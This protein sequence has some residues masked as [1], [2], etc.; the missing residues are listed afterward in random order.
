MRTLGVAGRTDVLVALGVASLLALAG[1]SGAADPVSARAP[2]QPTAEA[3]PEEP[4]VALPEEG[5][6]QLTGT[7]TEVHRGG[8]GE[9]AWTVAVQAS[10]VGPCLIVRDARDATTEGCG[11]EVPERAALGYV[12]HAGTDTP[13]G[14][15]EIVAGLAAASVAAV[16]VESDG[17]E[18]VEVA[19][20]PLPGDSE[21]ASWVLELDPARGPFTVIALGPGGEEIERRP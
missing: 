16:L 19:T 12:V 18:P 15:P 17:S 13:D 8:D 6:P 21:R 20:S 7:P 5:G 14:G 10:D 11:F 2:S 4:P 9:H 3:V 1:C